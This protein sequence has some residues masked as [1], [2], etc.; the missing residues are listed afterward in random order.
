[1]GRARVARALARLDGAAVRARVTRATRRRR[2][3]RHFATARAWRRRASRA[4]RWTCEDTPRMEAR[5]A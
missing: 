5:I 4:R 1:M 3:E 2:F